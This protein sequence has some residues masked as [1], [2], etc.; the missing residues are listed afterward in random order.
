MK[1]HAPCHHHEILPNAALTIEKS[2]LASAT[3][4]PI[5][6]GRPTETVPL[7]F[8]GQQLAFTVGFLE[9]AEHTMKSG[10]IHSWLGDQGG[11]PGDEVQ[12]PEDDL[13]G[14]ILVRRLKLGRSCASL[15]PRH[16]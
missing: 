11:E 6:A 2:S 4:R 3:F 13:R 16:L 5:P 7:P 1:G 12:R 10:E 14:A 15:R 9:L 8:G